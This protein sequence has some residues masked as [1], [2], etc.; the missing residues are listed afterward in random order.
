MES[1]LTCSTADLAIARLHHALALLGRG[2][3]PYCQPGRSAGDNAAVD[4]HMAG[5]DR[6]NR[7]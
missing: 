2:L 6:P 5:P 3:R 1:H 4:E 7:S